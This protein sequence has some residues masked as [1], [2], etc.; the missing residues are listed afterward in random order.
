MKISKVALLLLFLTA[1]MFETKGNTTI[2]NEK[3]DFLFKSKKKK[4]SK[5]TFTKRLRSNSFSMAVSYNKDVKKY[6]NR[7]LDKDRVGTELLL[8]RKAIYFP[9]FEKYVKELNLPKELCNIPIIE[10]SLNPKAK[11]QVGARGLW[12]FMPRTARMYGL[13]I[14]NYVDERC[15]PVKSTIAGLT[16]LKDLHNKYED[17]KLAIAAYN[18]GPGRVSKAIRRANSTQFEKIK[19]YLPKETRGYVAKFIAMSYI[20]ENYFFH[21]LRPIYPEYTLQF[22]KTIKVY[23]R[24]TLKEIAKQTGMDLKIIKKLNPSYW[25]G[26]IPP[27]EDGNF[28][29]IPIFGKD[30]SLG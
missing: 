8:G 24:T 11:S 30:I 15:D 26:I 28:I 4:V 27:S 19:K 25:R 18:C 12:Q 6:V 16:Y 2:S 22:S 10:S 5:K 23:E 7:F 9:I 17:W 3:T 14:D 21:D 1:I 29:I 20:T 13:R